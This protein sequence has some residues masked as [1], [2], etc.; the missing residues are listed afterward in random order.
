MVQ[1]VKVQLDHRH[2]RLRTIT[3]LVVIYGK[4]IDD[5]EIGIYIEGVFFGG[6]ANSQEEADQL[7]KDCV[8]CTGGVA[9]PKII[10]IGDKNLHEIFLEA[11][12]RFDKIERE[13]IETEDILSASQKRYKKK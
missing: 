5:K 8:N 3:M 13:M 1:T 9:I 7:A 6:V 10:P 2:R 4:V 12:R 11:L